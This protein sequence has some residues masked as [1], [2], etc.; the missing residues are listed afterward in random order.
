VVAVQDGSDDTAFPGLA[1][2]RPERA[3]DP[4]TVRR[5]AIAAGVQLRVMG[6]GMTLAPIADL[7][8]GA[9]FGDDPRTAAQL[10]AATVRGLASGGVVAAPRHFPGQGAASQDPL[11]GPAYVGLRREQLLARDVA[12]F[13]TPLRAVVMSNA[14][15]L[16]FDAVTPAT[17]APAAHALLR[18]ELG[19][20][21]VAIAD[22]VLGTSAATGLAPGAAAVAALAAGC[23]MVLVRDAEERREAHGAILAALR[24][25]ELPDARLREAVARVLALKAATRTLAAAS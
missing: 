20:E 19:F 15:Y 2:G 9:S 7:A 17:L 18:E 11:R 1:G 25:G 14:A 8:Q 23:D 22:N 21:G 12:P 13:R 3:T 4:E 5:R 6:V 10:T 24:R 16:A